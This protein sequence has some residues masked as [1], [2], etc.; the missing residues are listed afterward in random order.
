MLY[1]LN[2]VRPLRTP[3]RPPSRTRGQPQAPARQRGR[4]NSDSV[5]FI[6]S[7]ARVAR[8]ARHSLGDLQDSSQW[9]TSPVFTGSGRHSPP[10]SNAR[11][12]KVSVFYNKLGHV[13]EE[14]DEAQ[15]SNNNVPSQE[16]DYAALPQENEE[17]ADYACPLDAISE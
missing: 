4:R 9:V 1:S 2:E 7:P 12:R 14:T 3:P 15:D 11:A 16:E 5:P 13:D 6:I 10:L 8:P 17:D